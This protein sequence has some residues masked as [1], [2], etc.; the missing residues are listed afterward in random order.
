MRK[1]TVS[2]IAGYFDGLAGRWDALMPGDE[3]SRSAIKEGMAA[4]GLRSGDTVLDAGCGTGALF[5][6]LLALAGPAG[7]VVGL[8]VSRAMIEEAGRKFPAAGLRLVCAD[9]GSFLENE[10][11][12]SV[13][14]VVC[15]Q[16]FP[17]FE[18]QDRVIG[19]FARLL[20]PGGRFV[21]LHA[22][23][24]AEVNAFHA[25][26]SAPVNG[27]RLPPVGKVKAWALASGFAVLE[28]AR[29]T[30]ALSVGR[31]EEITSRV[32]NRG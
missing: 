1:P 13:N 6:F 21:V 10:P 28:G 25:T 29:R 2:E 27:H 14:A 4:L 5:P 9:V 16:A 19:G 11:A 18:R 7:T 31:G 30:G 22:A 20:P 12:G 8:D 15:F 23:S 24:S 3:K 32:E 17:H 26:L